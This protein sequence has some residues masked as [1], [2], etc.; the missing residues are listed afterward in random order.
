MTRV[1]N[2]HFLS[3]SVP[4]IF[5]HYAFVPVFTELWKV[6]RFN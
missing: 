2:R 1:E 3:R 6:V 5:L 4:T